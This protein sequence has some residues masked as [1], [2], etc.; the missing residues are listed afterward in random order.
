MTV[1]D[2][3][4]LVAMLHK[5]KSDFEQQLPERLGKIELALESCREKPA[6]AEAVKVLLLLLHSLGGTAGTF[7][8]DDLGAEAQNLEADIAILTGGSSQ[9]DVDEFA[10]AVQ[11]F[12]KKFNCLRTCSRS[13]EQQG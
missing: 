5:L 7:G 4:S 6:D 10:S 1:P 3:V 11:R 12:T 8:F 9:E 2:D 13:P